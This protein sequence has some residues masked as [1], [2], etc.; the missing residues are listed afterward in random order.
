MPFTDI[1]EGNAEFAKH[2]EEPAS[3]IP[4]R[5]LAILT[6]ME[7]R[8]A[9]LAITGLEVGDAKIL[10]NA[11]ARVTDDVLRTLLLA[12]H[13]LEVNRVA[14]IAHTDCGGTKA[15][16]SEM[17]A[18]VREGSGVESVGIDYL[19]VTDQLAALHDDLAKL[20]ECQL[21]PPGVEFGA[22]IYDVHS[23]EL[24]AVE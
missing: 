22:F 12:T 14:L 16:Q 5:K 8:I 10:R 23:G 9:P 4:Q 1:L 13:L 3:G 15:T 24:S 19:T 17:E 21:F 20:K 2:Y 18:I 11:G 6:C 7:A